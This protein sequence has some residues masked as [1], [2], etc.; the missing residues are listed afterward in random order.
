MSATRGYNSPVLARLDE[1]PAG[2]PRWSSSPH[3]GMYPDRGDDV[4]TTFVAQGTGLLVIC[5]LAADAVSTFI[6][7]TPWLRAYQVARAPLILALAAVLPV[8]IAGA[9]SRALR[10]PALVAYA[11]SF[12]GLVV[13]LGFTNDFNFSA[14][15]D[16]LVHVPAQLLSETLPLNG[17]AYI[18]TAPVLL[19][20]LC[21]AVAAE[22]SVR[23]ERPSAA[24]ALVV[25]LCFVLA[26]IATTSA[27]VGTSVA[28][29]AA[30]FGELMLWA[31]ARQAILERQRALVEARVG[32]PHSRRSESL[33]WAAAGAA[34]AAVLAAA[35]ALA[36]PGALSFIGKPAT[37]SRPTPVVST[38][39]VDPVDALA[40]LRNSHPQAAAKTLFAVQVLEPWSGYVSVAALDNYD[41]DVW[42]FSSTFKP[43]GGRVP[44]PSIGDSVGEQLLQRYTLLRPTGLPFLPAADRP[45]QVSG[46]PVDA[47]AATGMLAASP[48]LPATYIVLS[49]V[50]SGTLGEINPSESIASGSS[51]PGGDAAAY[52][53]LPAGSVRDISAG[54]RFS[55]NLTGLGATP[56]LT[57]LQ[58]LAAALR[59]HERR[60]SPA[61]AANGKTSNSA[62]LA[63][64]S[65]AQV[66]NAVTVDRAATPEQF[67]TFYAVVARYL[68]VPARVVTGFRAPEVTRTYGPLSAGTYK[69]TNRDAWSW[70]ELPVAGVGWVIVGPTPVAT[71]TAASPPPEQVRATPTT[72]AKQAT[73][74]P[75]NSA[76]HAIAKPVKVKHTEPVQVSWPVI[77]GVG[78]PAA[79]IIGLLAGGLLVPAVRRRLRRLARHQAADPALLAAGAWLELLDGLSRL[80]L[81]VAPSATSTDVAEKITER[82]G[83]DFGPPARFVG[84]AAD[85]ALY[86]TVWPIEDARARSAWDS[87]RRLYKA[88]R[89]SLGYE[90]AAQSLMRVGNAPTRPSRRSLQRVGAQT[91]GGQPGF[92]ATGGGQLAV[93]QPGGAHSGAGRAGGGHSQGGPSVFGQSS[94]ALPSGWQSPGDRPRGGP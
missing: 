20:W 42:S 40:S 12:A 33:G 5:L 55:A 85:Q 60:V 37:V 63:G 15:W 58:D 73:A 61:A 43:T 23:P 36:V 93:S 79:V 16:G 81:D 82:F 13:L 2:A 91:G 71:T 69:L 80:G 65:L 66:I 92:S 84:R 83:T 51:V 19:T 21:G 14:V 74:L 64:T 26:F 1:A 75:G 11:G 22:L 18:L 9:L 28:E 87:Q 10:L 68:G 54:V 7:A 34:M 50:P 45:L 67:A 88:M 94:G 32:G 31:L 49:Q 17:P 57:F 53:A 30:L 52:I 41:G 29:A 48:P 3:P 8:A 27:P 39:V 56:S 4:S 44:G 59:S 90:V 70:V 35:L 86:S 46:L 89:R 78:L 47:N 72:V 62:A 77:L 24:S 38:V 76:A 25:V 6:A